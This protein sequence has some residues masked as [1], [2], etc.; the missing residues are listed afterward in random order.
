MAAQRGVA[1]WT[2]ERS[3]ETNKDW[4]SR[5][6]RR[7]TFASNIGWCS[8]VLANDYAVDPVSETRF[9]PTAMLVA[10]ALLGTGGADINSQTASAAT[11]QTQAGSAASINDPTRP[12]VQPPLDI[13]RD[14]IPSPDATVNPAV[15][16]ATPPAANAPTASGANQTANGTATG[17]TELEKQQNG[18]H[19]LHA[20]VD[21]VLLNCAVLDAKGQAVM[22]LNR[23][24]FRV[25]EDG[26]AETVNSVQ[27]LDLPVSMGILIDD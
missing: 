18:M 14:P 22:D 5:L 4:V 7:P 26:V 16:A 21:E 11:A 17:P 8:F 6:L 2:M 10:L 12:E 25:W 23:E 27:H 20:N 19:I 3:E 24:D 13:D 1:D 15:N 9:T